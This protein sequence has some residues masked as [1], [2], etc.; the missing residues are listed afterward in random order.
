MA[1]RNLIAYDTSGNVLVTV[2]GAEVLVHS[3]ED[4][5]PIWRKTLEHKLV[6]VGTTPDEVVTLDREGNLVWWDAETG[7]RN[8][9]VELEGDEFTAL[10]VD[11]DGIAAVL[12][13]NTLELVEPGEKPR[14]V[15][16]ARACAVAW[17]TDGGLLGV[18]S[19]DGKLWVLDEADLEVDEPL[20]LSASVTSIAWN[21]NGC[22]LATVA[23]GV[24]R[25][26][27]SGEKKELVT[28]LEG[29]ELGWMACSDDGDVF[30]LRRD[31][32]S[33]EAFSFPAAESVGSV[34]YQDRRVA[35]VA[36]GPRPWLAIGLDHGDGNKISLRTESVHRTKTFE[37]RTHNSWMLSVSVKVAKPRGK[38][39]KPKADVPEH[40]KRPSKLPKTEDQLDEPG[41]QGLG[42]LGVI[43]VSTIFMWAAAYFPIFYGSSCNAHPPDSKKAKVGTTAELASTA[44]DAAIELVQRWTS[45]DFAGALEIAKGQAADELRAEKQACEANKAACDA[46][47]KELEGKVV[48]MADV[49]TQDSALTRT[50]V[51]TRVGEGET[52]RYL[53]EVVPD[54]QIFKATRRTPER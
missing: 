39:A 54:G 51:Y 30:A 44:K 16:L 6:G 2:D 7:D 3:G 25:I 47:K 19:R 48:T 28:R 38:K 50:R 31:P 32:A 18:G 45:K 8:D 49:L 5:E 46:R 21:A 36:F 1:P 26:D 11:R 37:G 29:C 52:Q 15:E 41:W 35:G 24:Y 42:M 43:A 9:E 33:V 13:D 27:E 34:R 53:V 22:W 10:A 4:C 14:R 20:S 23:D 40:V 12:V 17:S